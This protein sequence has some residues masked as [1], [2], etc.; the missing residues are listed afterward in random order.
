MKIRDLV[1]NMSCRRESTESLDMLT[2][3]IM[4][5]LNSQTMDHPWNEAVEFKLDPI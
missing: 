1:Q 5:Q 2:K 3:R 4:V